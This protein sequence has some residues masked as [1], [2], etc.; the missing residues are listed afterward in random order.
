[1]RG[2]DKDE[3]QGDGRCAGKCGRLPRFRGRLRH[4]EI[5][6]VPLDRQAARYDAKGVLSV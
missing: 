3:H 1:M 6:Y 5:F 4:A 2:R